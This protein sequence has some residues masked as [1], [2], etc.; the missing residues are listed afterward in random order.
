MSIVDF[1]LLQQRRHSRKRR[2]SMEPH[3]LPL[4]HPIQSRLFCS[5]AGEFREIRRIA[6]CL[7][8]SYLTFTCLIPGKR[9]TKF[10]VA[11]YLRR[12]VC[13]ATWC[14]LHQ[15]LL[16]CKGYTLAVNEGR[17]WITGLVLLDCWS[18]YIA[19]CPRKVN[20]GNKKPVYPPVHVQNPKCCLTVLWFLDVQMVGAVQ[21]VG[22]KHNTQSLEL[23]KL[24]YRLRVWEKI[25][26]GKYSGLTE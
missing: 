8:F 17:T 1:S 2:V 11:G 20:A 13:S 14:S 25:C 15:V 18:S 6:S 12:F 19:M 23:H 3:T 16:L 4:C 26:S 22:R 7:C 21:S 24:N 9:V 10:S 5:V